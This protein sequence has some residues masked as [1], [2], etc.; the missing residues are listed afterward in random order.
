[1]IHGSREIP[2]FYPEEL[3]FATTTPVGVILPSAFNELYRGTLLL[4]VVEVAMA[5]ATNEIVLIKSHS[6]TNWE[7]DFF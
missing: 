4:T 7:S 3:E 5:Q 1:M 6:P 2:L